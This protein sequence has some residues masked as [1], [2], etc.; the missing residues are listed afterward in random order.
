M[1][2][3]RDPETITMPI[4]KNSDFFKDLSD[5]LD[6]L[7]NEKRLKILKLLEK[8]PKDVGTIASDIKTTYENTKNHI[9]K[10]L[11]IGVI[12]KE[13]GIKD[14]RPVM[15]YV[16]VPGGLEA[17]LRSLGV[18]SNFKFELTDRIKEVSKK[19][20]KEVISKV[21]AI[22]VLGGV[23]DGK[24]FAIKKDSVKIGRVNPEKQDRYD[25]ENDIVLSDNYK[26]VTR[27]S[28]PHAKLTF[29]G[30][31]WYLEDCES[32]SG[33]YLKDERLDKNRKMKLEDGDMIELA[34]GSS[35]VRLLF[36]LPSE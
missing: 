36:N 4:K 30:D 19:L 13:P 26:A 18:F 11:S 7:S 27:V 3:T 21:P 17:I 2:K 31:D 20:S 9:D 8:E 14:K 34:K 6:V 29:D 16:F 32:K 35:G 5:Y 24:V 10:L 15:N 1:G 22:R 25:L 23:D 28:K 12:R 33:T